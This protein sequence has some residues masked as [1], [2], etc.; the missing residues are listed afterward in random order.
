M[1]LPRS[2]TCKAA[3][4]QEQAQKHRYMVLN[5]YKDVQPAKSGTRIGDPGRVHPEAC[6]CE[7]M[8]I[9]VRTPMCV[10][11][12]SA[13]PNIVSQEDI[14]AVGPKDTTCH[15]V[16]SAEMSQWPRQKKNQRFGTPGWLS[17]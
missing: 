5:T 14:K 15:G 13:I 17:G 8:C 3:V 9:C 2:G 7:C 11:I 6:A 12:H 10:L 1:D 4:T 16:V